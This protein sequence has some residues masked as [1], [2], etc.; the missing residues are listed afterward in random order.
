MPKSPFAY[1]NKK[2]TL[3]AFEFAMILAESAHQLKIE[4][5]REIVVR[6]EN[7]LLEELGRRSSAHF[8][9]HMNVYTLAILKPKD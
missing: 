4:M 3:L 1:F 5:D 2:K 9:C 6:G 8:A 7:L